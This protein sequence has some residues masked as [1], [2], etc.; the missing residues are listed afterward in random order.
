V[1][2]AV[3]R[4]LFFWGDEG[5]IFHIN[6]TCRAV[7]NTAAAFCTFLL[8]YREVDHLLLLEKNLFNVCWQIWLQI[9]S[10]IQNC[11]LCPVDSCLQV[12]ED[13][14][15]S[16]EALHVCAFTASETAM[17]QPKPSET[18]IAASGTS[19]RFAL[20]ETVGSSGISFQI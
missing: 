10:F 6:N 1:L 18:I 11:M 15:D 16:S 9:N 3:T 13:G 14:V 20:P 5:N 4:S 19:D 2:A 12:T 17:K 7:G 8:V